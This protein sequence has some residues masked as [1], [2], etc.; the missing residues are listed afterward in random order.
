MGLYSNKSP[1]TPDTVAVEA[2]RPELTF[3]F[4]PRKTPP[5]YG[6]GSFTPV[7]A[8][9]LSTVQ[10]DVELKPAGEIPKGADV[11]EQKPKKD[12]L[13]LLIWKE[14]YMIFICQINKAMHQLLQL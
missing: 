10:P 5:Q 9:A 13:L 8:D 2:E 3:Q 11:I 6:I 14:K 12:C 1:Y 4:K 7:I